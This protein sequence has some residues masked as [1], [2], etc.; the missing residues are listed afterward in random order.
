MPYKSEKIKLSETQDRRRKL[1]SEDYE[2][3]RKKYS[4]GYYS[5]RSLAREYN[6]S[7]SLILII[8]NPTSA[9]RNRNHIKEH[10]RDY[11]PNKEQNARQKRKWRH[12]KQNLY[13]KGE[14]K[15]EL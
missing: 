1:T 10:W 8:V 15:G 12:Y 6:V 5:L 7:H 2:I 11:A 4:T 9:E 14:L 3:I 13:L